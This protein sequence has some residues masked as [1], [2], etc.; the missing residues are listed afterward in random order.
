MWI[1][2]CIVGGGQFSPFWPV[3]CVSVVLVVGC[4]YLCGV[5]YVSD[6]VV[7]GVVGLD[8]VVGAGGDKH[9]I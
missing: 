5:G 2:I 8:V 1:T 3:L 4:R 7:T 6:V 9:V